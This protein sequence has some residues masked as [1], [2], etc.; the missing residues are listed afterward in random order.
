MPP[1]T[2]YPGRGGQDPGRFSPGGRQTAARCREEG[3]MEPIDML[4][5]AVAWLVMLGVP[6]CLMTLVVAA[7]AA[8]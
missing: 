2:R 7:P 8:S 3:P 4:W 5:A 1:D 6:A